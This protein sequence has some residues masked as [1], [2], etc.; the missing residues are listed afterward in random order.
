MSSICEYGYTR[1]IPEPEGTLDVSLDG[2]VY[3]SPKYPFRVP[4][5]YIEGAG[6][7]YYP[8]CMFDWSEKSVITVD[9]DILIKHT[10]H[11][12]AELLA[13]DENGNVIWVDGRTAPYAGC[14][15]GK[16]LGD[17]RGA[18]EFEIQ[19]IDLKSLEKKTFK[20]ALESTS[21]MDRNDFFELVDYIDPNIIKR[22]DWGNETKEP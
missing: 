15:K 9:N 17:I 8:Q 10:K 22:L 6:E 19:E 11:N 20:V 2:E 1:L 21:K 13:E 5:I 3:D 18:Q 4:A 12:Y 7:T 16:Y 14:W